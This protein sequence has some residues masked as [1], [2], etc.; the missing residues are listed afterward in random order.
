MY[1]MDA[2]TSQHNPELYSKP[3][4]SK[5]G[6]KEGEHGTSKDRCLI[7]KLIQTKSK[8]SKAKQNLA[9][10]WGDFVSDSL[11]CHC[12]TFLLSYWLNQVN[13][14]TNQL[15][16]NKLMTP[17]R[18]R[19]D[20]FWKTTVLVMLHD[21][22]YSTKWSFSKNLLICFITIIIQ[23]RPINSPITHL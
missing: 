19:D 16:K 6:I 14:T 20:M 10:V 21:T 12:L 2:K 4:K 23:N 7:L 15:F 3:D 9:I 17:F 18:A 1:F 22:I 5:G 11:R 8:Q 13:Q